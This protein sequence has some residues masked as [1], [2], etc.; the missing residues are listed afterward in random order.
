MLHREYVLIPKGD[1]TAQIPKLLEQR[2]FDSLIGLD[3]AGNVIPDPKLSP[4]HRYGN[5]ITPRQS[6][7][8]NKFEALKQNIEYINSILHD[9]N[10]LKSL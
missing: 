9:F 2:W 7:F 1:S 5:S 3:I 10:L 6:W 4:K 8:I